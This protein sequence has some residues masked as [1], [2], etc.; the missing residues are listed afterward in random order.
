MQCNYLINGDSQCKLRT[1]DPSGYCHH[2]KR[3]SQQYKFSKPKNCPVCFC[4]IHQCVRP[5]ECGHWVHRSCVRRSGKA[6]CP[7]CRQGLSDIN[8]LPE[9]ISFSELLEEL[10]V[11]PDVERIDIPENAVVLAVIA[12]QLYA[13]I[14]RPNNRVLGLDHFLSCVVNDI[15]PIEH[16]HHDGILSFLYSEAL[17]IFF[18]PQNW[19]MTHSTLVH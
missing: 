8:L 4:T 5:L 1:T 7:I 11:D 15:I 19:S 18:D 2:H 17:R 14:L 10:L 9:M 3:K 12:Y 13:F 6:E 16:P